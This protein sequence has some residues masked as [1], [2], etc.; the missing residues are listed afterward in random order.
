MNFEPLCAAAAAF[1]PAM[2]D[3]A[4]GYDEFRRRLDKLMSNPEKPVVIPER[5]ELKAPRIRDFNREVSGMSLPWWWLAAAH[6]RY[7]MQGLLL[8]LARATFIHTARCGERKLRV[9]T[10]C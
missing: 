5:R 10:M 6:A 1:I 2:G 7:A 8:A 3:S 9:R 4:K